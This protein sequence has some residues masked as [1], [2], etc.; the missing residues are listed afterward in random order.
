[1]TNIFYSDGSQIQPFYKHFSNALLR[2]Y[3][4]IGSQLLLWGKKYHYPFQ[5]DVVI[6]IEST[7]YCN[8]KCTFCP[9]EIHQRP[10]GIM[11]MK[12]YQKII[13]ECATIGVKH[14]NLTSF[15]ESFMDKNL[16]E[17][18]RYAKQKKIK[19][20]Y[21]TTNGSLIRNTEIC[22]A[23]IDS[24]LNEIRFSLDA[25]SGDEYS[26]VRRGKVPYQSIIENIERLLT[27]KQQKKALF[28]K[29]TVAFVTTEENKDRISLFLEKWK[30]KADQIHLQGLHNWT[31]TMQ[32]IKHHQNL[33][34]KRLWF[35]LS[36]FWNGDV[37][38]C[39]ADVEGRH[40]MGNVLASSILAVWNS[41]AFQSFRIKNL[42]KDPNI[43]CSTCNLTDRDSLLWI[44]KVFW[45]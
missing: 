17:K 9:H 27:I 30:N 39:C 2:R 24:G 41:D 10:K 34:C 42:K 35:T 16:L 21:I 5:S 28:P 36:I 18:I 23:L 44:K 4:K 40:V 33:P 12:N 22:E 29:V 14:L 3:P 11:S 25:V 20:V 37:A 7:N 6:R 8:Y 1:M 15:G 31:G 13:E 19:N 38:V 43:I 45:K 26:R 32:Y